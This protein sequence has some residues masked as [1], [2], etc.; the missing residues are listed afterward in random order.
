MPQSLQRIVS[1]F[2]PALVIACVYR[3]LKMEAR[4][5]IE[6]THKGIAEPYPLFD[7]FARKPPACT[8]PRFD[9]ASI[10]CERINQLPKA[11]PRAPH[12]EVILSVVSPSGIFAR[13]VRRRLILT[14]MI[15]E[16]AHCQA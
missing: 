2:Y 16:T 8:V 9:A 3:G 10:L 7:A 1:D 14:A 15:E 6:P 13:A 4:V 5:G 12:R 11:P